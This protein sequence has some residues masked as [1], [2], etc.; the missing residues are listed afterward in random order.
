M[1]LPLFAS[2][3]PV[4]DRLK[5]A[6]GGIRRWLSGEGGVDTVRRTGDAL[7]QGLVVWHAETIPYL[8]IQAAASAA[9]AVTVGDVASALDAVALSA[10]VASDYEAR[11]FREFLQKWWQACRRELDL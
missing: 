10:R 8:I 1:V 9:E 3:A 6:I 7:A 5:M 4:T 11:L 2:Y